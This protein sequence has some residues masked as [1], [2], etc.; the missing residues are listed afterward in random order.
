MA[1]RTKLNQEQITTI[2]TT[3]LEQI[4]KKYDQTFTNVEDAATFFKQLSRVQ[5]LR[6]TDVWT[7]IDADVGKGDLQKSYSYK[8]ITETVIKRSMKGQGKKWDEG[9]L[10]KAKE[11]VLALILQKRDEIL[12]AQSDKEARQACKDVKALTFQN[13]NDFKNEG[14]QGTR[15]TMMDMLGH[16]IDSQVKAIRAETQHQATPNGSQ[17]DSKPFQQVQESVTE[18]ESHSVT[19]NLVVYSSQEQVPAQQEVSLYNFD[20]FMQY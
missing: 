17:K 14:V 2:E 7:I 5:T 3:A 8:H 6:F 12:N 18:K 16:V 1:K 10:I 19:T 9:I 20:S 15:K 11:Y 4:N 13:F